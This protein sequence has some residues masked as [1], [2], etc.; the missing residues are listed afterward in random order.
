MR[1]VDWVWTERFTDAIDDR[2]LEMIERLATQ[3]E[4][5]FRIW[6]P[7]GSPPSTGDAL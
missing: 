3:P 4:S 6:S 7:A 5:D 1:I 2:F